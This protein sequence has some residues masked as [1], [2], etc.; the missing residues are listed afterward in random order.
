MDRNFLYIWIG[1]MLA[2]LVIAP[3]SRRL[4]SKKPP[5]SQEFVVAGFALGGIIALVKVLIKLLTQEQLQADL[6]WDGTIALCISSGLGIF[7]SAK[8]VFKLL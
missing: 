3:L 1:V 2:M 5:E 8:E 6:E 7:L 4:R